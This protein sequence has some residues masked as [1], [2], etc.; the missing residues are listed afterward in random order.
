MGVVAAAVLAGSLTRA[1]AAPDPGVAARALLGPEAV[2]PSGPT[3]WD[4]P[5]ASTFQDVADTAARYGRPI[6]LVRGLLEAPGGHRYEGLD[7][8]VRR[9]DDGT[10]V[11][12][13]ATPP[14]AEAARLVSPYVHAGWRLEGGDLDEGSSRRLTFSDAGELVWL[15]PSYVTPV[16]APEPVALADWAYATTFLRSELPVY[17]A[18][19][20][21]GHWEIQEIALAPALTRGDHEAALRIYRNHLPWT[22]GCSMDERPDQVQHDYAELCHGL[23]KLGCF[24]QLH[25]RTMGTGFDR[26]TGSSYG[27]AP[28]DTGAGMLRD[29]GID[30]DRFFR[31]LVVRFEGVPSGNEVDAGRL[32]RAIQ[33]A[34]RS[35]SI[36]ASLLQMVENPALDEY[37]RLRATR[38][39][40]H[41]G[42]DGEIRGDAMSAPVR[43]WLDHT[44]ALLAVGHRIW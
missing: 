10:F 39:L 5:E 43:A 7:L 36:T 12:E 44:R 28:V 41:L 25:V 29:T 2:L 27:E 15:T 26:T 8:S 34:G 22:R 23:G 18:D 11:L 16:K 13:V 20:R 6:R 4:W 40:V 35:P 32:A 14:A 30:L 33:E 17:A 24:L 19:A 38:I 31:G 21:G 9:N 37:N 3:R 42:K 1:L